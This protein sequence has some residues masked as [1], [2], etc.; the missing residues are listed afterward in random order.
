MRIVAG[1]YGGRRLA[2]PPGRGTRPTSDRVREALFS[3]LGPLDGR[4]VLDLYAGSGALGIEAL[5]RGAAEA[6]F[7]ERDP[8]AAAV[9]RTNLEALGADGDVR[10]VDALAALRDARRRGETYDLVLCDP[11][12]R[13]APDLGESLGEALPPLLAP[14]AR[15]V[16]ESDRRAPLDLHLLSL[17]DERRYGDTVIRIHTP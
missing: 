11:P 14:Q 16:T 6:V 12:Y 15:V 13:L 7:V 4:R 1:R 8:R 3:I 17:T 5:S 9:L 10:R 2:A